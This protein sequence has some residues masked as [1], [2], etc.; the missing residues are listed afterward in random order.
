MLYAHF[1]VM[2][3]CSGLMVSDL[4][5][6]SSSAG[7]SPGQGH[8]VVFLDKTLYSHGASLNPGVQMGTS[9]LNAG[10]NHAMDYLASHPGGVEIFLV[11]SWYRN[12]DKPQPDKPLYHLQS[13]TCTSKYCIHD[14][15][16]STYIH[17]QKEKKQQQQTKYLKDLPE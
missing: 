7:S 9:E 14:Y 1:P 8:F 15:S 3:R 5:S 17:V 4:D 12:Q 13:C 2:W 16:V 11:I 10:C 6:G